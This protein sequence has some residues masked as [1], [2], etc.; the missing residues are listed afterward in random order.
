MSLEEGWKQ[1]IKRDYVIIRCWSCGEFFKCYG[2]RTGSCILFKE[3]KL[4]DCV[5][6]ECYDGGSVDCICSPPISREEVLREKR[7]GVPI[8]YDKNWKSEEWL[9]AEDQDNSLSM[10]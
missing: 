3:R 5:C 7:R 2:S 4:E 6:D 1:E 8:L 10:Q 9:E